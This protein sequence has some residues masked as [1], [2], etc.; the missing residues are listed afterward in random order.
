[1]VTSTTRKIDEL[2]RIMLT[3]ELREAM[4]WKAGDSLNLSYTGAGVLLTTS[5]PSCIFC[6]CSTGLC[7]LDG[8]QICCNCV[9]KIQNL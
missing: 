2:G 6:G 8:R 5:Q 3:K 4:N 9:K 1:M 7:E